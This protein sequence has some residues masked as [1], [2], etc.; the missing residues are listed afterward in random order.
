M[1]VLFRQISAGQILFSRQV[2]HL[3]AMETHKRVTDK[4]EKKCVC[5]YVLLSHLASWVPIQVAPSHTRSPPPVELRPG[6][7]G[8]HP[9]AIAT[10]SGHVHAR[11]H[12]QVNVSLT[13]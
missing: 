6:T 13:Q 7:C 3:V 11:V 12:V 9:A 2:R 4:K 10:S 1:N 8:G 5:V